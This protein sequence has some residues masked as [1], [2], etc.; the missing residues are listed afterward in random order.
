MSIVKGFTD[1]LLSSTA[2]NFLSK[3]KIYDDLLLRFPDINK[4]T[5]EINILAINCGKNLFNTAQDRGFGISRIGISNSK[6]SSKSISNNQTLDNI[7]ESLKNFDTII[8]DKCL[9]YF[10]RPDEALLSAFKYSKDVRC[11][12]KNYANL[13]HRLHFLFNGPWDFVDL[14]SDIFSTRNISPFGID[15]FKNFCDKNEIK[16]KLSCYVNHK[17]YIK[18]T[19]SANL[20]PNLSVD[21]AMFILEK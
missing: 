19:F 21:D 7:S 3:K 2:E 8:F 13:K 9:E 1:S 17:G 12:V 4:A 15:D 18:S 6:D 10:T 11:I 16:V 14:G 20:F 5:S